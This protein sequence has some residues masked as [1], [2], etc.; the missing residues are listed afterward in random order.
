MKRNRTL[1]I[2]RAVCILGIS[3]VICTIF[4]VIAIEAD[5]HGTANY[6]VTEDMLNNR[7]PYDYEVNKKTQGYAKDG[8]YNKYFLDDDLQEVYIEIDENNLNYM[9]QNAKEEPSVMAKSVTI[10]DAT[11]RYCGLKTKGD[12]TLEHSYD[13]N[14]GSDRFSF[15][16]NFGKY[17][18]K[19]EFGEKQTF[20]GCEKISFNNFYFDKSMMRELLSYKLLEEM[21]LPVPQYGLAKL[22]INNEYYGVY[23]MV[24]SL[25]ET[26]ME[27]YYKVDDV[28][29]YLDKPKD[30]TLKYSEIIANPQLLCG[31]EY[32]ELS[33]IQDM[34]LTI[35]KWNLKLNNLSEGKDFAGNS[36]DVN[37][38]E[39][40]ELLNQIV[41]VDE[42]LRY[43]ATHSWLC[44]TDSMF[45]WLKN[46]GL[47]IDEDGISTI[48]P[49]D[50][51]LSF[52]C[53]YPAK[54]EETA[55]LDVDIMYAPGSGGAV[56]DSPEEVYANFPLFNVIYQNDELRA[57]Y[58]LYMEECS[59]IAA[60]GGTI[61]STQKSYNPGYLNSYIDK[62][63]SKLISAASEELADNVYY[64][65]GINQPED[66]QAALPNLKKIVALRAVAVF[67][68]VNDIDATVCAAGCRLET[69][70]NTYVGEYSTS[71]KLTVVDE[72]TGIYATAEYAEDEVSPILYV[73]EL[74]TKD[75]KYKEIKKL[76]KCDKKDK[77]TV[78]TM[79][80][81]KQ[82]IG[83]YTLT[84][85]MTHDDLKENT[86]IILYKYSNGE[87]IELKTSIDDNLY[88][89]TTDSIEYIVVMQKD[90]SLDAKT[91]IIIA[92]L[93][94]LLIIVLKIVIKILKVVLGGIRKM[95][96]RIN[97]KALMAIIAV[98]AV[99]AIAVI[100]VS[101][102][103]KNGA[104]NETTSQTSTTN[105][106][107]KEVLTGTEWW[108]ANEIGKDYPLNGDGY[109]ELDIYSYADNDPTT[110][111]FCVEAYDAEGRFLTTTSEGDMWFTKTL[112]DIN[113]HKNHVNIESGSI[114]TVRITRAGNEFTIEYIDKKSGEKLFEHLYAVEKG[115]MGSELNVRVIA[116]VGTISVRLAS[117]SSN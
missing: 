6:M 94:I 85:P 74:D 68:Q 19:S 81:D 93:I 90:T 67:N 80:N 36:I 87:L 23:F 28:D 117:S 39:Y 86:K 76:T 102:K 101:G 88:S 89:C 115:L 37:S 57:Q 4:M 15:T 79:E 24:E 95:S 63:E 116:Q 18:T 103:S 61:E 3:I 33:D 71:G 2:I 25:D 58:Y 99:V 111:A 66:L 47:Y 30:T 5:T 106:D 97:V 108:N 31:N 105:V 21:G 62:L 96:K 69:L 42:A 78:Y 40:I 10:G 83:K 114:V 34:L 51:D 7:P 54:A 35:L 46:Y 92:L 41:D 45:V 82:P 107:G 16:V 75:E 11:V 12:Y 110:V 9:L 50:Y 72:K 104:E 13:D 8:E 65:N 29:G 109:V 26:I 22:Y 43:F 59:K 98:V 73:N 17:V 44:Q 60:L 38:D 77:V 52:G 48:I 91:I 20:F 49:W 27:Q 84:I 112:G 56:G 53:Y 113:P 70:G 100:L 32:E 55:N 1:D 14:P 64:M